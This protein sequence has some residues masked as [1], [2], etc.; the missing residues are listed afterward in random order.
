[1]SNAET[2]SEQKF[3][4]RC[5]LLAAKLWRIAN[6]GS[7]D[8][9]RLAETGCVQAALGGAVCDETCWTFGLPLQPMSLPDVAEPEPS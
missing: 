3:F 9:A 1:M 5:S 8:P 2:N 6:A 4:P 7:V